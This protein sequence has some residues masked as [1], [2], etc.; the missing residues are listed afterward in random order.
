MDMKVKPLT[1][2]MA[3]LL[4]LFFL[5]SF[6]MHPSHDSNLLAQEA[7]ASD[8]EDVPV[9]AIVEANYADVYA[10]WEA[11]GLATA[12]EEPIVLPI[13]A[14]D[15]EYGAT[16]ISDPALLYG[17]ESSAYQLAAGQGI[18]WQVEIDEPGLYDISFEYL[19]LSDSLLSTEAELRIN[20]EIPFYEAR[21]VLFDPLWENESDEFS[22]N[23]DGDEFIGQQVPVLIWQNTYLEDPAALWPSTLSVYLDN[24]THSFELSLT[25]GEL[26]VGDILL[27]NR[28]QSPGYADYRAAHDSRESS[29]EAVLIPIEAER[30][31]H[32]NSTSPRPVNSRHVSVSPYDTYTDYLN[33]F[34]G[35]SWYN[36]GETVSWLFEV[37]ASGFYQIAFRYQQSMKDNTSVYRT[38]RVNGELLFEESRSF[39][40]PP[41]SSFD[42]LI[43]APG[44]GDEEEN[45]GYFIYL[46]AGT[47]EISLTADAS[48]YD[49]LIRIVEQTI[50]DV[51]DLGLEIRLLTG[52]NQDPNRDWVISDYIDNIDGRLT[53]MADRLEAEVNVLDR[54]GLVEDN[55]L[56]MSNLRSVMMRL[57]TLAAEP[58]LLPS[59]LNQL[60]EGSGSINQTLSDTVTELKLQP[61][62]LDRI[63]IFRN[64]AIP[65]VENSLWLRLSES[66]KR[67]FNTFR[68]DNTLQ[69]GDDET[70]TVWVNRA[71]VFADLMQQMTD[72]VYTSNT[73]INIQFSLMP[74]EGK[75][76]LANTS[77]TNP[78][79]A[80]G[81]STTL[82]FEL[83]IRNSL[84]DLRS[85]DDFNETAGQFSP[86]AL[87][88]YV[89]D[90]SIFGLPETQDF[91][92]TFYRSDI[93]SRLN[94]PVPDTWQD[95]IEI[96]PEL[97]RYGMNYYSP[98]SS[99]SAF[100]PFMF[101]SPFIYQ[102]GGDIYRPDGLG[103]ALN[104]EAAVQA[105]ALMTDLFTIYGLPLQVPNFYNDFRAGTIPIGIGNFADYLR[106]TTAAPEIAGSWQIAPAPGIEQ[107]DGEVLRWNTGS[108]QGAMIFGNTD[109]P[110]ESWDFLSWWLSAETQTEFAY[111]IQ[112]LYGTEYIWNSANLTAFSSQPWPEADK[113]II[114]EQWEWL[115]EVP[116]LPGGYMVER[117]L[118]NAWNAIVFDDANPRSTI[119]DNTLVMERE[120]RRKLSEFGYLENGEVVRPFRV[121]SIEL[122]EE[123]LSE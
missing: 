8:E 110:E 25:Q 96:L 38:I 14:I 83:A 60:N 61:L 63:F 5:S 1:R 109:L 35:E 72:T 13:T 46:E 95:V 77:G 98:L 67:F 52:N 41:N 80:L 37:P 88:S 74:D 15:A 117:E 107:E 54:S 32:K 69:S 85:F 20:G 94:I 103:V 64:E 108:A 2:V 68:Q 11:D 112:T 75:L 71:R 45:E 93:L 78:D 106:L 49:P 116:K 82:P 111:Q 120:L 97:Q 89:L 36:S 24:G 84:L 87:L 56:A 19:I 57:R 123:W 122:I 17:K 33:V 48:N 113:D 47:N 99:E 4:I 42:N 12:P 10:E 102:N 53:D 43:F 105:M 79:V 23:D 16:E 29:D 58:N 22:V 27:Q 28:I 44:S 70:V 114:L 31:L 9:T 104:E 92:V 6:F 76:I 18:S 90:D 55:N 81:V 59:R 7:D 115:R 91:Y 86:G 26:L 119:D 40:F 118:S 73:G 21:R 121:P 34:G 51:S 30:N 65:E 66:F 39:P 100:K 101:T 3:L 50:A 62:T